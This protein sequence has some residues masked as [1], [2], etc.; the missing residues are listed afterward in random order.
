MR[1]R[2]QLAL[3]SLASLGLCAAAGA[4][5]IDF[6]NLEHIDTSFRNQLADSE[7]AYSFTNFEMS[8]SGG[9]Q[10]MVTLFLQQDQTMSPNVSGP[11]TSMGLTGAWGIYLYDVTNSSSAGFSAFGL[12]P[13]GGNGDFSETYIPGISSEDAFSLFNVDAGFLFT[14]TETDGSGTPGSTTLFDLAAGN[15]VAG[16]GFAS[17][18]GAGNAFVTQFLVGGETYTGSSI[19]CGGVAD[20]TV[21]E[22]SAALLGLMGAVGLLVRKRR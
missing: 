7:L 6:C 11:S 20:F 19:H 4:Q 17:A 15:T 12:T 9:G 10:Y 18:P 3:I 1:R 5:T 8:V 16:I 22:P 21:P 13:A 2:S 14:A